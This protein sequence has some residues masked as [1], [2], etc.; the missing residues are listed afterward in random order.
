L[1]DGRRTNGTRS[2]N[3][4]RVFL[5]AKIAEIVVVASPKFL[6]VKLSGRSESLRQNSRAQLAVAAPRVALHLGW[7]CTS[8]GAAPRAALHLGWRCT[9]GGAAPRAALHLGLRCT[10]G[11]AAPRVALHLG[12]RRTSVCA[13]RRQIDRPTKSTDN[14]GPFNPLPHQFKNENK[15]QTFNSTTILIQ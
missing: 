1:T 12:L 15:K 5:R 9:S 10:S 8:G 3:L 13:A 4:D 2:S 7:R 11:C 6:R 14:N